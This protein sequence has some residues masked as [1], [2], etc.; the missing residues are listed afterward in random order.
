MDKIVALG[1]TFGRIANRQN[2]YGLLRLHSLTLLKNFY[3]AGLRTKPA[4]FCLWLENPRQR[5]FKRRAFVESALDLDLP[6][7]E[8]QKTLDNS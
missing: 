4:L 2:Q 8:I 6:A 3:A 7:Q 5:N 1:F